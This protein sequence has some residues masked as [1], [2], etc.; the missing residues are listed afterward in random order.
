MSNLSLSLTFKVTRLLSY[1]ISPL[2][3]LKTLLFL[4]ILHPYSFSLLNAENSP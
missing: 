4:K 1:L 2:L 3:N